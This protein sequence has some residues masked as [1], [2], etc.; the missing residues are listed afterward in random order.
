MQ[1]CYT[2]S[3][4][5][6]FTPPGGRTMALRDELFLFLVR[7]RLG[8]FQQDLLTDLMYMSLQLAEKLLPGQIISIFFLESNP[9]MTLTRSCSEMHTPGI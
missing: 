5:S 6:P 1:Y 4:S 2:N 7:I 8:L 3:T 9:Y